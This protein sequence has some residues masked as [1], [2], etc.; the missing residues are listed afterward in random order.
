MRGHLSIP[1]LTHSWNY[2]SKINPAPS[3]SKA[4]VLT[5]PLFYAEGFPA[6]AVVKNSPA[7]AGD[8]RDMGLTPGL[9]RSPGNP[10]QYACLG[11]PMD[12]GGWRATVRGVAK[13]Q[14]QL[15]A[16]T[17]THIRSMPKA[18][19]SPFRGFFTKGLDAIKWKRYE[20]GS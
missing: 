12:R 7:S 20:Q 15:R 4:P 14:T 10:L 17:Y 1:L 16:H 2:S 13:G 19:E 6:G 8:A 11:N 3:G 5:T 9:G 18:A